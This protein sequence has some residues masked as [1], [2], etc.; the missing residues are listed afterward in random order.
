[1]G[2][3]PLNS[4]KLLA[5]EKEYSERVW[6]LN[7]VNIM[8][9]HPKSVDK[10]D[11]NKIADLEV[12]TRKIFISAKTI[13]KFL[14]RI[15]DI[16][17]ERDKGLS[18]LNKEQRYITIISSNDLEVLKAELIKFQEI[19]KPL[20]STFGNKIKPVVKNIEFVLN[21]NQIMM[22]QNKKV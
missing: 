10:L 6:S 12:R 21:D 19:T 20:N 22:A 17:E 4:P 9:L 18:R 14:E 1:V 3:S 2:F 13:L 15:M 16:N 5:D 8:V 7:E 11:L